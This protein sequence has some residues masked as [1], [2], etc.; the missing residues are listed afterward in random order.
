MVRSGLTATRSSLPAI[1]ET[2][3]LLEGS[4]VDCQLGMF[5]IECTS[6]GSRETEWKTK[7]NGAEESMMRVQVV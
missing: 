4:I 2:Y 3:L 7:L 1:G 6:D 5:T